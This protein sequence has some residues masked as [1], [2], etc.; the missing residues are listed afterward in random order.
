MVVYQNVDSHHVTTRFLYNSLLHH[1][2][3]SVVAF[4]LDTEDV[5]EIII[6]FTI[7]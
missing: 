3:S 4:L 7:L 6:A 1:V 2:A 5:R